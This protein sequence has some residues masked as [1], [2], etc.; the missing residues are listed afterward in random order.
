MTGTPRTVLTSSAIRGVAVN[1][2]GD[3]YV[4]RSASDSNPQDLVL[5][6]SGTT[7][8]QAWVPNAAGSGD[9]VMWLQIADAWLVGN[10]LDNLGPMQLVKTTA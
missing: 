1:P 9:F 5:V 6:R 4:L 10:G 8:S 3:I 2:A 7:W